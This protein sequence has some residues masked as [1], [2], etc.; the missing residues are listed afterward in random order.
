MVTVRDD[1]DWAR[2]IDAMG[3]PDGAEAAELSEAAGRM[4]RR[5]QVNSLVTA[6]ASG[7]SPLEVEA[8]CQARGVP[9][10]RVMSAFH[11]M[12]DPHLLDRGFI[13]EIEQP[14]AGS[15]ALEGPCITGSKMARPVITAA[16]LLGEHTREIC[17]NELGMSG[18]RLEG[19]LAAGALEELD[20]Q[21]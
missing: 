14:G 11:Q 3:R 15:I 2:L 13:V 5:D 10:G 4:E 1:E 17:L 8:A 20:P 21:D 19:L 9:A 18:D 12:D 16:P 6:W 7:L